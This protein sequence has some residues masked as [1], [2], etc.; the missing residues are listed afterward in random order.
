MQLKQLT[1]IALILSLCVGICKDD[2]LTYVYAVEGSYY[3]NPSLTTQSVV[4]IDTVFGQYQKVVDEN[5]YYSL[6]TV[7]NKSLIQIF[8]NYNFTSSKL[9][10]M[11]VGR[12][13]SSWLVLK[14]VPSI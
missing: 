10:S 5:I 11:I 3:D 9:A 13:S 1:I 4:N 8:G 2:T 12:L 6:S 7:N 14:T